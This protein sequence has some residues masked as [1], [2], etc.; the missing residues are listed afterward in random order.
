M[1][2]GVLAGKVT[3]IENHLKMLLEILL[4]C[5]RIFIFLDNRNFRSRIPS[6]SEN[7]S[8][9]ARVHYP[10]RR[11]CSIG[12]G[13][14]HQF[15]NNSN[16]CA[17]RFWGDVVNSSAYRGSTKGDWQKHGPESNRRSQLGFYNVSRMER[18]RKI[19]GKSP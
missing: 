10:D 13:R 1:P 2:S 19:P 6:K 12:I 9:E 15:P 7:M 4:K 3:S 8:E 17:I 11:C 16:G 18:V 5:D 14:S